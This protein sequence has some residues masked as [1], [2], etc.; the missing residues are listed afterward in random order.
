MVG[1]ASTT[2]SADP[3]ARR[4]FPGSVPA[5]VSA[6]NDV[7]AS[8]DTTVEGE[9]Y[10]D[11]QDEVGAQRLAT[12]VST[13]GNASYGKYLTPAQWI[14]RFAPTK[15]DL[16][17]VKKYLKQSGMTITA[18]PAS[19][20]Y[21]V[22]RGPAD[23][24]DAAFGTALHNYRIDGTTVSA[25]SKAP[26]LPVSVAGKVL[27]I[28]L[29]NARSKL[30]R[31][32]SV[33]QGEGVPGAQR[34]STG[35][36]GSGATTSGAAKAT[37][38]SQAATTSQCSTYYGEYKAT[39]PS[40]YGRTKFPTFVCGYL[41]SQLRSAGNVDRLINSGYDGSGVTVGIVD[42]YA[43]PTI[44]QDTNDYMRAVYEPLMSRFT[45]IGAKPADFSDEAL[46]GYPSGWQTEETI[47]VQSAHSVA[48]DAHILYS[49]AFN[50]GGGMDIALSAIL[51]H[52]RADLV[53]NSYGYTGEAV[54]NDVI[55]GQQNIHIQAAGTG[56]G[57]Y[58]SSGDDGDDTVD[59]GYPAAN[60]P[61]T[62]P[63]VTAVGGTSEAINARGGYKSEVGWGD[64][65]DKVVNGKYSSPLPGDTYGGG[66]G[67]GVSTVIAEPE[68]QR[69]VVPTSLSGK[70]NKASRVIPDVADLA[71]PYTGFQIAIRP[72]TDD[73]T[74]ATGDLEYQTWGGTSLASP[75]VAAKM[76][77]TQQRTGQ[78]LGFANPALYQ[79][80]K[81]H[82]G[83]F[84]DIV[85]PAAPQALSYTSAKSGNLYLVTLNQGGTLKTRTGYD[86]ITGI[87]SLKT[88]NLAAALGS[89][90][91]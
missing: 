73:S 90:Q 66:A 64:Q 39:M 5:F 46:C 61:A 11:L 91:D 70:G 14:K 1:L 3:G 49:G 8:S 18:I 51:D 32:S 41:P 9:V 12:A 87:G 79:Q 80:A 28:S 59:L 22:F 15:A 57:L 13:P 4:S 84:H 2:S 83:A 30:T 24:V 56:I 31:P 16:A 72:I 37:P 75:I 67:G 88:P 65:L 44:V 78:Q 60:W 50:C 17:S 25:P 76:A 38:R 23:E 21:V 81:A 85:T 6:A 43:S 33:R 42:A 68:Y 55:R 63:Y 89:S 26:T 52:G 20:E 77:I 40:A 62:S 19:R 34:S 74:L 53:S 69:G 36:Q 54:G 7:G 47:D 48:P 58:F 27:G 29:G 86:D 45:Q 35:V 82:P 71:D 10:L